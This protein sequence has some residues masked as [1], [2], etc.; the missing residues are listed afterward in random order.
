ME[1][2]KETAMRTIGW[3]LAAFVLAASVAGCSDGGGDGAAPDGGDTDADAGADHRFDA[4]A[5]ALHADLAANPA[6]GVS[7]AVMENGVVTY[8]AAFGSK[9]ADGAEPLTPETLMQIGSTTKQMTAT[10]LLRKVEDG[11]VSRDDALA[12]ALPEL[13]FAYGAGWAGEIL[14]RDLLSHQSGLADWTLGD[15]SSDDGELEAF[16]YGT[17]E[18]QEYLMNPPGAFWNYSNPNFSLL[19]LVTQTYDTRMWPDIVEQDVFAPLGMARTFARKAEVEADGDY[20]LSYGLGLDDLASGIAGDVSMEQMPDPAW[21]R[22]AGFVWTTPTQMMAWARFLM[23]G[24]PEVLSDELRAEITTAHVDTLYGAGTMSYGYG[25]FV[26]TGYQ[27]KDGRW[28]AMPVWEHGGNTLSFTNILYILPEQRF[29]I[30]IISSGY[31]TDFSGALDAA[32]TT[33]VD[34]PE[35]SEGP[36]YVID[37]GEFDD[38]V[39]AYNDVFNVGD[40]VVTR[41]GDTLIVEMPTLELYGYTVTPELTAVSSDIFLL[42]IDDGTGPAQFDLTFVPLEGEEQSTYIRNRAFVAT[43]VE[44]SPDGGIAESREA[45]SREAVA[46]WMARARPR[47]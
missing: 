12:D 17:F 27:A 42:T 7:A 24:D 32:L 11:A 34:L 1:E 30:D 5:A 43:R 29:A 22:P 13:E 40:V 23:D 28:Y 26:E 46:A 31:N 38:H 10:A 39:G 8:A 20:A 6:Y 14:L 37:P 25:M 18:A 45:P 47:W 36:E 44:E 19:G 2:G 35:P 15:P 16:T 9:D 21:D 33:L 41:D 4:F 3:V